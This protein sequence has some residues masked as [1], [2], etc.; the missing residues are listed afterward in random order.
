MTSLQRPDCVDRL[1]VRAHRSQPSY[2][3]LGRTQ[4][5]NK[6]NK[7]KQYTKKIKN[8]NFELP[9]Y[10]Q[11]TCPAILLSRNCQ[12]IKIIQNF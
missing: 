9:P 5:I 10:C 11:Y 2:D 7:N 8:R 1:K 3:R 12:K 6:I 4:A